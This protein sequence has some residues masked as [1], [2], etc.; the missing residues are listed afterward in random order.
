MDVGHIGVGSRLVLCAAIDHDLCTTYRAASK[1]VL[2]QSNFQLEVSVI[3]VQNCCSIFF[4]QRAVRRAQI[5]AGRLRIVAI[6]LEG[7][8]QMVTDLDLI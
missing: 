7:I 4:S 5:S 1:A 2:V 6:R 8:W 3:P